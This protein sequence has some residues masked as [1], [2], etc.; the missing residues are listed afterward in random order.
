MKNI[1]TS[2]F[3]A[4]IFISQFGGLLGL[5]PKIVNVVSSVGAACGLVAAKD[6]NVT[7]G[8]IKQ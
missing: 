8:T 2:L 6:S 3:A 5:S 4:V 1:R 7:G